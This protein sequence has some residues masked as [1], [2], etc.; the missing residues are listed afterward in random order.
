MHQVLYFDVTLKPHRVCTPKTEYG[1]NGNSSSCVRNLYLSGSLEG[2]NEF[3][4]AL[5]I[6]HANC[7]IE[8]ELASSSSRSHKRERARFL[9]K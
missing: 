5:S 9:K 1:K 7:M 2:G 8:H 6:S 3:Q 4:N